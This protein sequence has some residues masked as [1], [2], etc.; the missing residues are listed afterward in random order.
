[1]DGFAGLVEDLLV[2]EGVPRESV[3]H[4]YHATLPGFFR[5]EKVFLSGRNHELPSEA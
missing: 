5:H 2:A 1:M 3:K 4:D